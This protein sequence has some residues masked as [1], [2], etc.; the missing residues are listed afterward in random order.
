MRE[1]HYNDFDALSALTK[2]DFGPWGTS[3]LVTQDMINRFAD[4]TGDLQ[5]IHVDVER[6]GRESPY[7]TTIA[8]GLLTLSL[9]PSLH[10]INA[11]RIV[12]HGSAIN[13]GAKGM[14]FLAPVLAGS[15]IRARSKL[16]EFERHAKGTLLTVDFSLHQITEETAALVYQAQIL[17]RPAQR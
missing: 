5:W 4:L 6:A 9:L 16:L 13:Y 8:H 17:Y 11:W 14:R 1:I 10:P 2:E 7:G 12:G 15:T 3:K